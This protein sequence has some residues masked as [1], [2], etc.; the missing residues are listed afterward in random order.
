MD[1]LITLLIY[2]V[3]FAI[4]AYG[5]Y[6]VCVN[7]S[8]PQPVM[9]ICGALL[10]IIILYFLARQIGAPSYSIVPLRR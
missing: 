8:L 6:W 4:F 2:I 3:I 9:W 10:L 1:Q 5:L 7:F